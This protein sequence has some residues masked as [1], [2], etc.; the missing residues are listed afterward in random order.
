MT[1]YEVR[2]GEILCNDCVIFFYLADVYPGDGGL[3]IVPGSHRANFDR[4][5]GLYNGGTITDKIP[6]GVVNVTPKAGDVVLFSELTTHG[7]SP[8]KPVDRERRMV[9]YRYKVHARGWEH[10]F[11]DELKA[12]LS[13]ELLELVR[14]ED[15]M[16]A[17]DIGSKDVI[18]LI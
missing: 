12:A 2:D 11:S 1:R 10:R 6:P 13:P 4:P 5:E 3:L 18:E 7:V 9:N 17:K 14:D 16:N 15:Y 8:W